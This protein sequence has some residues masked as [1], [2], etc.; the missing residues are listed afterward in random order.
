MIK[1]IFFIFL[2]FFSTNLLCYDKKIILAT[3]T[4][5]YDSGLLTYLN[6]IFKYKFDIN[7]KVLT[8]GTGQA[9][10]IAK[11]GNVEILMVHHKESELA[12]MKEGYGLLRYDLMFN[13]YIIVGPK[14]DNKKCLNLK[15]KL[16]FIFQ[17]KLKFISRGDDSGT[18]KKELELWKS[19]NITQKDFDS[20]YFKVGQGM[21][22]T[23]LIANEMNAYTLTDRSTWISFNK[24]ENLNIICEFKPPLLNQYGVI[25]VNPKMNNNLDLDSAKLYVDW[26]ISSEGKNLINNFKKNNQQLFFFNYN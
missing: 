21:G 1:N 18:H 22:H 7:V 4:S 19:I 8:L 6:E 11:D 2:L 14:L 13:D 26:L 12:F 23:L 3:T 25:I 20:N 5:T 10:R 24:K 16:N 15:E 17:N 9:L